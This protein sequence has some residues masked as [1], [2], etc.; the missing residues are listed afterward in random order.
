V[1]KAR[2]RSEA[3]SPG[4]PCHDRRH[5]RVG[6]ASRHVQLQAHDPSKKWLMSSLSSCWL[7]QKSPPVGRVE[8]ARRDAGSR[9]RDFRKPNSA[10]R[11]S[12]GRHDGDPARREKRSRP[13]E[14]RRERAAGWEPA[15]RAGRKSAL[16]RGSGEDRTVHTRRMS[17][18]EEP[19]CGLI[20]RSLRLERRLLF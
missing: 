14:V 17:A 12:P 19:T 6:A 18:V 3:G 15:A 1:T 2:L 20:N 5:F 10:C 9:R 11:R 8:V 13:P 4:Q 16:H 7:N